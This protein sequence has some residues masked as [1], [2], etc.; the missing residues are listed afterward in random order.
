MKIMRTCSIWVAVAAVVAAC[1]ST[2]G[3]LSRPVLRRATR[4]PDA[5]VMAD[6]KPGDAAPACRTPLYDPSDRAVI[7]LV[8]SDKGQGD[9]EVP[10]DRYGV[11]AGE[12]LRLECGSGRP[13][14]VARR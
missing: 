10:E 7:R 3:D 14:G 8:R 11:Q 4:V 5:F 12:L 2:G 9:Y 1:A 13:I 6:G